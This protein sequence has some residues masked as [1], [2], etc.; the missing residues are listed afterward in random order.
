MVPDRRCKYDNP[1]TIASNFGTFFANIP[2]QIKAKT[3][4]LK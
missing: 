4:K 1:N 3:I 2:Y